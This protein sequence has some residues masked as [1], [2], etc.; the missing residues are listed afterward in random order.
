MVLNGANTQEREE[1]ENER[2]RQIGRQAVK[3]TD[4]LTDREMIVNYLDTLSRS[5]NLFIHQ[6]LQ[7]YKSL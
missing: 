2:Y 6:K 4:W 1:W 7:I 5:L 3:L